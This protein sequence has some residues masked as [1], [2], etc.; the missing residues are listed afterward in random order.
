ME[1]LGDSVLDILVSNYLVEKFT[2]FSEGTLSKI[3]AS[4]VN[5]SCLAKLAQKIHLGN[6]LLLGKGE[7]RSGGR[8]KPSILADAFEAV[9]GAAFR[10]AFAP[11]CDPEWKTLVCE[12]RARAP[13]QA[14]HVERRG[15]ARAGALRLGG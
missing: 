10:D 12:R 5:E 4:V 3:R 1:F 2:E 15:E 8:E 13:P 6:Y 11:A 14:T 9:A 7:D